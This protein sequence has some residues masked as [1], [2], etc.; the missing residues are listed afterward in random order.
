MVPVVLDSVSV[1]V[2]VVPSKPLR[3]YYTPTTHSP[4]QTAV[5]FEKSLIGAKI[6]LSS[7]KNLPP[8]ISMIFPE[9]T[10]DRGWGGDFLNQRHHFPWSRLEIPRNLRICVPVSFHTVLGVLHGII[11]EMS[12]TRI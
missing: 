12:R 9:K 6:S 2:V 4:S 1:V 3:N 5:V 11:L 7:L 10:V 8:Q